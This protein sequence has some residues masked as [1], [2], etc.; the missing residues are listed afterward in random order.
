MIKLFKTREYVVERILDKRI[1]NGITEYYLSWEGY[2]SSEN[3]W[4]PMSNLDCP[5]LIQVYN[6][7]PSRQSFQSEF[8]KDVLYFRYAKFLI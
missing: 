4:E 7:H 8:Q 3:T 1:R 6:S 2:P 5:G